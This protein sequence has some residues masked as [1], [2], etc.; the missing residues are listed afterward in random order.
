VQSSFPAPL[1]EF[2]EFQF[3]LN[4]FFVSASMV[5]DALAYAAC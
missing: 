2:F 4:S 1:T 3:F 5:I